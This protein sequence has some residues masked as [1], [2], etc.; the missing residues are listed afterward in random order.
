MDR[1]RVCA[2]VCDLCDCGETL[3]V[4]IRI[5]DAHRHDGMVLQLQHRESSTSLLDT[6]QYSPTLTSIIEAVLLASGTTLTRHTDEE[7]SDDSCKFLNLAF[8][9]LTAV[10]MPKRVPEYLLL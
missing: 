6:H 8:G 10:F 7:A 1:V 9:M 5:I 3:E 2:C 4:P